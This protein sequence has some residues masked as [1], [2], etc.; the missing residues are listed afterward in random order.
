MIFLTF[1]L[2]LCI[3]GTQKVHLVQLY[4]LKILE[5]LSKSVNHA[6]EVGAYEGDNEICRLYYYRLCNIILPVF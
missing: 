3:A 1:F 4:Y 6:E 2:D 5:K